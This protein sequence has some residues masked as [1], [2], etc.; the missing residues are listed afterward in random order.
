MSAF[1]VSC[2]ETYHSETMK[3]VIG[4]FPSVESDE[5][6]HKVD[7]MYRKCITIYFTSVTLDC[8]WGDGCKLS[9]AWKDFQLMSNK[10]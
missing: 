7:G 10:Q 1:N 9:H 8:C 4:V 2:F 6:S 5:T 3:H